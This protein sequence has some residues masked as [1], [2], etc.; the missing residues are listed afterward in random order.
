MTRRRSRLCQ[1]LRRDR[2]VVA[3]EEDEAGAVEDDKNSQNKITV[4]NAQILP[5]AWGGILIKAA[6]TRTR[7]E[8]TNSF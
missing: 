1:N 4:C 6:D 2:A 8:G 5:E 7:W 3:G